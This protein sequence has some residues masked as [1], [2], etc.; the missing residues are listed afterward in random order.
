M[1]VSMS[2]SGFLAK[3]GPEMAILKELAQKLH[4]PNNSNE[5]ISQRFA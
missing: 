3:F 4:Q 2:H 5:R 1:G